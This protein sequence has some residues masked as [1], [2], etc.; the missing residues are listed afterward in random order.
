MASGV[1]AIG[2]QMGQFFYILAGV[3]VVVVISFFSLRTHIQG[4]K[5]GRELEAQA[6]RE[7][8]A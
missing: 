4:G 8:A 6:L 3:I 7:G 2:L 5:Q 1:F